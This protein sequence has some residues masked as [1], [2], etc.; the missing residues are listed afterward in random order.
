MTVKRQVNIRTPARVLQYFTVSGYS[1]S[2]SGCFCVW[3]SAVESSGGSGRQM[4][5]IYWK[6]SDELFAFEVRF[7]TLNRFLFTY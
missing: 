1:Q 5:Q 4:A 2:S 7:Q 6:A 3:S